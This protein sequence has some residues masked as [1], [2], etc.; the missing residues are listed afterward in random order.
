MKVCKKIHH[1]EEYYNQ[2][3][4]KAI[5]LFDK[6]NKYETYNEDEDINP[7]KIFIERAYEFKRY[8]PRSGWRGAFI[9]VNK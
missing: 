8:P 5:E 7:S 1:L 3:W 9:L 4:D 6:S 2:N